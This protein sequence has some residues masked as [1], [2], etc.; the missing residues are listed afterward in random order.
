[1]TDL[2]LYFLYPGDLDTPTGGY[3]YDRRLIAE[4]RRAGARVEARALPH[5][6]AASC[7]ADRKAREELA[8][9]PDHSLVIIDGLAFGVMDEL[10]QA[11]SQRLR[12]IALCHHPLAFETGLEASE[13]STLW[14]TERR[15][16]ACARRVVVTSA[17]TG[18]VL[19]EDFSVPLEKVVVAP[20][21]TDRVSFAA[22]DADLPLLL[23]VASLTPRKGHDV[24]I[25]ALSSLRD[26]AWR[27]RFVGGDRFDPDW[28]ASLKARTETLGLTQRIEFA[29]EV[30][31]THPEYHLADLFV[32]PSLFEGY[33]MVF[34]EALAAGLP[35]VAARAGAVPDVVPESAGLLVP[36]GDPEALAEALRSLLRDP[37]RRLRLRDGAR[38][39]AAG[40][41]TWTDTAARVADSLKRLVAS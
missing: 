7:D 40:L 14:E 34:A 29:N 1:M 32:L 15:A 19:C 38:D 37:A 4:L 8:A 16:L 2:S 13:Q 5:L 6:V 39:A 30:E 21:G 27:A 22:A 10:A 23:C 35:I 11:E 25:E 12:L 36:P 31:D 9:L 41:P 3:R 28:A 17:F 18:R 20:P 24:L 33:G 26:L